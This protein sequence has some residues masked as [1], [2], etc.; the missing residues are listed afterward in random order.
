MNNNNDDVK[1]YPIREVSSITGV[2]PVTLRAWERRY[3]L[4][5]PLR[6]SKGH[7]V[8]NDEHIA[9]IQIITEWID[10]GVPVGKVKSLLEHSQENISQLAADSDDEWLQHQQHF[11]NALENFDAVKMG[12]VWTEYHKLYP[13]EVITE[14]LVRPVLERAD[15]NCASAVQGAAA[16]RAF[17]HAHLRNW[18]GTR[19]YHANQ[20]R[21]EKVVLCACLPEEADDRDTLLLALS[22]CERGGQVRLL[23]PGLLM[24]EVN[25]AAVRSHCDYVLLH[26][27]RALQRDT[28]ERGLPGLM[29]LVNCQ[30]AISGHSSV[31]H[32]TELEALGVLCLGENPG[33]SVKRLLEQ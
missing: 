19:I 6:T 24:D 13:A 5:T 22:A 11:L 18:I 33:C 15:A 17:L 30:V 2:H 16:E 32:Q 26:S 12:S 31:I 1:L 4:I 7:R 8:Y 23:Q 9:R 10:R 20:Q 29:Q 27:D 3:G 21:S 28:L 25:V 14:R